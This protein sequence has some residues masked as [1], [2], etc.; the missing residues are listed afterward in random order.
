VEIG[1]ENIDNRFSN[2]IAIK[3]TSV[4][5]LIFLFFVRYA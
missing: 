4:L 3:A 1:L 5:A 2:K